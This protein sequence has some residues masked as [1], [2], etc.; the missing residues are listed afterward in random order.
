VLRSSLSYGC[1][2]IAKKLEANADGL[3]TVLVRTGR[4]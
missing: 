2:L 1:I 3:Q 4:R